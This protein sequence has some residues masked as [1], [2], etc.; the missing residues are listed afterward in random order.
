MPQWNLFTLK[1]AYIPR[2]PVEYLIENVFEL[3]SLCIVYGSPGMFKSFILADMAICIAMGKEWLYPDPNSIG[4]SAKPKGVTPATVLWIDFDNGK[5][6]THERFDMLGK[7]HNA[8][9]SIPLF[10]ASMENPPLTLSDPGSI[11]YLTAL[12]QSI[13]A[14]LIVIDNLGTVSGPKVDENSADMIQ[15]MFNLRTVIEN[16]CAT[17]IVIHHQRK[18]NGFK[19]RDGESLRG[20]SSIESALDLALQ[21]EREP[22]SKEIR[23][24]STKSRGIDVKPFGATFYHADT[25]QGEVAQFFGVFLEDTSS[26]DAIR[27]TIMDVVLADRKSVV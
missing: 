14:R 6:R 17:I 4:K 25:L 15:I 2:P 1:D 18:S 24:K 22:G 12:I 8:P 23:I 7:G 27:Q 10:Y 16:T 13:G 21:V 9:D 26:E 19:T 20:H 5:R 11:I 3:P